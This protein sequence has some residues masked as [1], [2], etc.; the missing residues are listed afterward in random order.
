MNEKGIPISDPQYL[1]FCWGLNNSNYNEE[2]DTK[3]FLLQYT[4]S[5]NC[6]FFYPQLFHVLRECNKFPNKARKKRECLYF[7][8]PSYCMHGLSFSLIQTYASSMKRPKK[9]K[10]REES[11]I[12]I[13]SPLHNEMEN[14]S[15]V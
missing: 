7:M 5:T 11:A 6:K 2:R 10:E 12:R 8:L 4:F 13:K 1:L 14:K 9:K 15:L 3:K